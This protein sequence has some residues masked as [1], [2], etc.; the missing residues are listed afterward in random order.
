MG[1]ASTTGPSQNSEASRDDARSDLATSHA[2]GGPGQIEQEP[3]RGVRVGRHGSARPDPEI[4]DDIATWLSGQDAFDPDQ[5]QV[6][7][8]EGIVMLLGV[9]PD[10]ESKRSIEE[11]V[12]GVS[13]V[14]EVHDQVQVAREVP[15][16][17]PGGLRTEAPHA[18]G[19]G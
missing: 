17:E 12:L 8:Q 7:V 15:F 13:G 1:E 2:P 6:L 10:A 5:I 18:R 11:F 19:P 9:V 14:H 16:A 4:R 3:A